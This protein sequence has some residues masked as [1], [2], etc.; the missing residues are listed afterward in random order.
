MPSATVFRFKYLF[1]KYLNS[2]CS[3]SEL[4]ELFELIHNETHSKELQ[5][6][7]ESVWSD[8]SPAAADD[9]DTALQEHRYQLLLNTIS[10][11][12]KTYSFEKKK[13]K[14]LAWSAAAVLLSAICTGILFLNRGKRTD[15]P[16]VEAR[17]ASKTPS[18]V[19]IIK[20]S[21]GSTVYLNKN[22]HLS[23]PAGFSGEKR[24]VSLSGEAYFDV[25][26]D[27]KHPF[28]VYAGGTVV[29]VLG[30]A[31]NIK[32]G[33]AGVQVTVTR[34]KVR[35]TTREKLLGVLLPDMQISYDSLTKRIS[36]S[37]LNA[38]TAVLWK[39]PDLIMENTT[40]AEAARMISEHY[41]VNIELL[42]DRIKNCR[43]SV[44]FL[45]TTGLDQVINV[46]SQLNNLTVNKENDHKILLSGPGCN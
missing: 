5:E 42:D 25:S 40:L 46:V 36:R 31:F 17:A 23:Y 26:D 19:Q 9:P 41:G 45:N 29:H 43:F 10:R 38:M 34:G 35:V 39:E 3:P 44:S 8:I 6:L 33:A 1:K 37:S 27:K 22:S 12:T 30:T 16:A 24:E 20:L 7:L 4:N 2:T 13:S 15:R 21:D 28:L 14:L 11:E 32:T 18:Y